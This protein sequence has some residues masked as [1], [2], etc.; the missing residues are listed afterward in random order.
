[1]QTVNKLNLEASGFVATLGR[2]DEFPGPARSD[3]SG[4][5]FAPYPALGP[6]T[7]TQ[8]VDV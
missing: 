7:N 1:M 2:E 5:T 6:K 4:E 8:D 3:V